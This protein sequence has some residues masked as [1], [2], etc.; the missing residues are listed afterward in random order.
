MLSLELAGESEQLAQPIANTPSEGTMCMSVC[1]GIY[2][3]QGFICYTHIVELCVRQSM[4]MRH[5]LLD[6]HCYKYRGKINLSVRCS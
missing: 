4:G 5:R 3:M 1:T 6:N 2:A